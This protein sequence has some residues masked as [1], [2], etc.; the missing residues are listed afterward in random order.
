VED[1]GKS[2]RACA[3]LCGCTWRAP[4]RLP[5]ARAEMTPSALAALANRS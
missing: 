3:R 2:L 5:Q 4:F 1:E